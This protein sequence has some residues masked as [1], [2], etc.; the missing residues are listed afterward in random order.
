MTP[1]KKSQKRF[2]QLN[3]LVDDVT[4]TLPAVAHVAVLLVCFRHAMA[5]GTFRLSTRRISEATKLSGRH[6]V[7]VMA[8]MRSGGVIEQ[9][10]EHKG[11]L[12]AK[13]R[14]TGKLFNTDMVSG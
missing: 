9:L 5:G 7:R 1:K 2:E 14:I 3:R 6:V 11:P 13:Y 8:D 12:P 10:E 4:G